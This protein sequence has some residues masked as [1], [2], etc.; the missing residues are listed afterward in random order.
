MSEPILASWVLECGKCLGLPKPDPVRDY[1]VADCKCG[2]TFE[3][4]GGPCSDWV[5]RRV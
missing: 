1:E 4:V 5:A 3:R 2:L